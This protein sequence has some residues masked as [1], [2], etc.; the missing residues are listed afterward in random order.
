MQYVAS[1]ITVARPGA[2]LARSHELCYAALFR[3]E[4]REVF[5]A[6]SEPSQAVPMACVSLKDA[7]SRAGCQ[8]VPVCVAASL[9]TIHVLQTILAFHS[10]WHAH[11]APAPQ[12]S[13]QLVSLLQVR[14]SILYHS[15]R[16]SLDGIQLS[17]SSCTS[18]LSP[19]DTTVLSPCRCTAHLH[20]HRTPGDTLLPGTK[21]VVQLD[22]VQVQLKPGSVATINQSL[23]QLCTAPATNDLAAPP[24]AQHEVVHTKIKDASAVTFGTVEPPALL[25]GGALI[26]WK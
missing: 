26:A 11:S 18:S 19:R 9:C 2:Q 17:T 23:L 13:I 6:M 4:C 14:T 5:A 22:S 20:L 12:Q 3:H 16:V 25:H 21:A 15:L 8:C 1:S 7:G 24:E 10:F